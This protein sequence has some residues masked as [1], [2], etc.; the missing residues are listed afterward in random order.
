MLLQQWPPI[1][2]VC[3]IPRQANT[4]AHR[5]ANYG[6]R[7]RDLSYWMELGL[8]WLLGCAQWLYL[9]LVLVSHSN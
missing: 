3:Y 6:L 1:V 8:P 7:E 4:V 9:S 5:I 2:I